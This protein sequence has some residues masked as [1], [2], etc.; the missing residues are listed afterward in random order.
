MKSN[1]Q[2][3]N[4]FLII[5]FLI[6]VLTGIILRL[7]LDSELWLK[8]MAVISVSSA[9]FALSDMFKESADDRRGMSILSSSIVKPLYD[10]FSELGL[11]VDADGK[12]LSKVKYSSESDFDRSLRGIADNDERVVRELVWEKR[13]NAKRMSRSRGNSVL[14]V[15]LLLLSVVLLVGS[16]ALL[17]FFPQWFPTIPPVYLDCSILCSLVLALA[18]SFAHKGG[19]VYFQKLEMLL[20]L[21]ERCQAIL[22]RRD[23]AAKE[24]MK[25]PAPYIPVPAFA[26]PVEPDPIPAFGAAPAADPVSFPESVKPAYSFQEEVEPQISHE[27]LSVSA[28]LSSEEP[29][30]IADA[31]VPAVQDVMDVQAQA[32]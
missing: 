18:S 16:L 17:F 19:F 10:R 20:G 28:P 23:Q 26:A 32:E 30:S 6:I 4:N 1:R 22:D 2:G 12:D 27:P 31:D 21:K 14:R 8:L 11:L 15:I 13:S 5:A 24:E 25:Q 3:F 29:A 7:F 9:L